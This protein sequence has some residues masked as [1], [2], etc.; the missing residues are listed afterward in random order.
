MAAGLDG[1]A[2]RLVACIGFGI[3]A[4]RGVCHAHF[5]ENVAALDA[6]GGYL[7]AFSVSR[8][9]GEGVAFLDA[10]A[11]AQAAHLGNQRAKPWRDFPH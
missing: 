6:D 11:A 5:L 2:T 9:T 3:D 4:Y 7:G 8:L 10:V 1:I